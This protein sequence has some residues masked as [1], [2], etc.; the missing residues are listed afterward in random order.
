M[1]RP[2]LHRHAQPKTSDGNLTNRPLGRVVIPLYV[3]YE[4]QVMLTYTQSINNL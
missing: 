1:G 2:N 4:E 3:Y